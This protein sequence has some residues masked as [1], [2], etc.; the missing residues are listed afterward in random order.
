MKLY[1]ISGLGADERVFN[2]L[3]LEVELLPISWIPVQ[4]NESIES[5]AKRLS[6]VINQEEDFGILG[7]SF[8]GLIAVEISKKMDPQL[9]I[10]VSSVETTSQLPFLHRA[11][12]KLGILPLL[13]TLLFKPPKILA[14]ILFGAKNKLLLNQ[15]IEDTDLDF[16]KWAV[17]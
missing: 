14:N 7:V 3:E 16:A 5:Y 9:T 8:G 15:I 6:L 2:Y 1:G 11:F 13:P 4:K 10:L 17:N 12:G